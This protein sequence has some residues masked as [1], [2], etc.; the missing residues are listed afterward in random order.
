MIGECFQPSKSGARKRRYMKMRS[1]CQSRSSP[2]RRLT[3]DV[4]QPGVLLHFGLLSVLARVAR[5]PIYLA[6][7]V[8]HDRQHD[9]ERNCTHEQGVILLPQ[10]DIEKR[11]NT[12]RPAPIINVR[13]P[14]PRK[15]RQY[16]VINSVDATTAI[17]CAQPNPIN[18]EIDNNSR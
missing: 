6:R 11:I 8:H 7:H 14:T 17:R 13:T 1:F 16:E 5:V 18:S 12:P 2:P 15:N 4:L 9:K 10:G 3:L